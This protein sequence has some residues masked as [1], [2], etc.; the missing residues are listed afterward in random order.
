MFRIEKFYLFFLIL[1][2]LNSCST[3]KDILYFNTVTSGQQDKV[4]FSAGKIQPNDILNIIISSSS[5]ELAVAY[6]LNQTPTFTGYLVT[7]EGTVTLPVLGKI[8]AQELTLSDLENLLVKKLKD[9]NHL[10]NPIV[11]VR[12]MNAKF[13]VLG[14]IN[15]PGTYTFSEESISILQALGYAGDLTI[16][17]VRNDILIIREENNIKTYAK[18]DLTSKEWFSSPYYYIKPNDVIYVNPNGAKVKSAGYVG[19]LGNFLAILSIGVSTVLTILVL[20][21]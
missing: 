12:L 3:K 17:G 11:T 8:K 13:T 7:T 14:E 20:S 19:S 9:E 1:L 18:I 6:N 15:K 2:V 21:K 16:N 10:S 5:L 4:V